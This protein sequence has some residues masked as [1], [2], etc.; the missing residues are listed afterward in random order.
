MNQ[1]LALNSGQRL[2]QLPRMLVVFLLKLKCVASTST[3]LSLSIEDLEMG[4]FFLLEIPSFYSQGGGGKGNRDELSSSSERYGFAGQWSLYILAQGM[5]PVFAH[6]LCKQ[7]S[8]DL[9][10][11]LLW[12]CHI[13]HLLQ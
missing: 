8:L 2:P 3:F 13:G 4:F 12:V 1:L 10:S 5:D 11:F 7:L 9:H 6:I